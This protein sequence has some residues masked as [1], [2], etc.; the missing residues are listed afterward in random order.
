MSPNVV[1]PNI[2]TGGADQF[3]CIWSLTRAMKAAG[4]IYKASSDGTGSTSNKDVSENPVKDMWGPGMIVGAGTQLGSQTGSSATIASNSSSFFTLNNVS[5][6]TTNSIGHAIT[7]SGGTKGNNRGTFIITK[8]NSATS[9][10]IF[11]PNGIDDGVNTYTWSEKVSGTGS[12]TW[13]SVTNNRLQIIS[14]LSGM[15][16]NS[17]GRYLNL[18]SSSIVN[19][20]NVGCFRIISYNSASSVTIINSNANTGSETASGNWVEL[21]ATT[22]IYPAAT[23]VA[24]I[25]FFGLG[26][27]AWIVLQGPSTLKIPINSASV[28]QFFRGENI[29]Q[30]GSNAEGEIIGYQYDPVSAYGYLVVLPRVNGTGSGKLGWHTSTVTTITGSSSSATVTT[31]GT[32]TSTP[33]EFVREVVFWRASSTSDIAFKGSIYYQCVNNNDVSDPLS[34]KTYR[35]SYLATQSNCTGG[36]TGIAPGAG[37]GNNAFPPLGSFVVKGVSTSNTA[38]W[39]LIPYKY[40]SNSPIADIGYVYNTYYYQILGKCHVMVANAD[41]ITRS[42]SDRN[43][44]DGSFTVACGLPIVNTGAYVGFAFQRLDNHEDGD[45]DPYGWL[46]PGHDFYTYTSSTRTNGP[47]IAI[48]CEH[49]SMGITGTTTTDF[50][51]A[52]GIMGRIWGKGFCRRGFATTLAA[53]SNNDNYQTLRI[54]S[55]GSY[56]YI[57]SQTITDITYQG[58]LDRSQ[59]GSSTGYLPFSASS[60]LSTTNISQATKRIIDPIWLYSEQTPVFGPG[61]TAARQIR[62]GTFRWLFYTN[63]GN[64]G[65][66]YNNKLWVQLSSNL[67]PIAAGPWDGYTAPLQV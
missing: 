20:G 39:W 59:N 31:A 43:S 58:L 4:W 67:R 57:P 40:Y 13:S 63:G 11:N 52:Y 7:L 22:D 46:V 35:F 51:V 10:N 12:I 36:S 61:E 18:D 50:R 55:I 44:A 38:R 32:S 30:S 49:F 28:G 56:V 1:I 17:V 41:Y 29:I 26:P 54:A 25:G 42:T 3:K 19:S 5:G 16:S 60:N 53:G 24:Q 62:K 14:G 45:V 2:S 8:Y 33:I 34:E 23:D 48:N 64:A 21:D 6:M 15:T 37:T 65:D 27:S 66:L 9:V 47:D